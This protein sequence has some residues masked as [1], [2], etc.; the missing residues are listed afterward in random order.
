MPNNSSD[1]RQFLKQ[2]LNVQDSGFQ[3][4]G[5]TTAMDQWSNDTKQTTAS[6]SS[7]VRKTTVLKPLAR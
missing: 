2:E 3:V 6:V 7:I 1:S 4:R 5:Y